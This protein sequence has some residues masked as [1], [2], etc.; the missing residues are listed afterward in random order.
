MAKPRS[1]DGASSLLFEKLTDLDPR[2]GRD[3][4]LFRVQ[5]LDDLKDSVRR[6]LER[7]IDTRRFVTFEQSAATSPPN[8]VLEY[9]I[10]DWTTLGPFDVVAQAGYARALR[11]AIRVYE[12]RLHNPMVKAVK[13][14]KRPDKLNFVISGELH[15]GTMI[16]PVSFPLDLRHSPRA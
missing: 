1:I 10:P 16:E 5:G 4:Q 2:S 14:T 9:G 11:D 13:D 6:E 8:T 7:L 15:L 3:P 12:P